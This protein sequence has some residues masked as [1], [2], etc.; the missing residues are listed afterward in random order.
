MDWKYF[1]STFVTP[2]LSAVAVWVIM[3]VLQ[4]R[5]PNG[6]DER[7]IKTI[8]DTVKNQINELKIEIHKQLGEL[9][10]QIAGKLEY[11]SDKNEQTHKEFYQRFEIVE[12]EN[13]LMKQRLDTLEKNCEKNHQG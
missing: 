10:E 7:I 8:Q 11:N 4:R 5:R 12:K 6:I 1:L 13:A 9:L 3:L 2:V